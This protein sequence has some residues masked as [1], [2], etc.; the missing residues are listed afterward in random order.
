MVND[1]IGLDLS[2]RATGLA[3]SE[4]AYTYKPKTKAEKR[5]FD[6]LFYVNGKVSK[7][8]VVILE[9]YA[10]RALG[11]VFNIGELGGVIK[12]H[13]YT[14]GIPFAVIPPA[15]LKVYATGKGNASKKMMKQ[16]AYDAGGF[17][18]EDDNQCDA[19]W[20]RQM[21]QM[22]YAFETKTI[23]PRTDKQMTA[24]EKVEWPYA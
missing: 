20:L 7:G 15:N 23:F 16:A 1:I 13:F 6:I 2:L 3:D 4:G 10:M 12:Y 9:G 8:D 22:W 11:R 21:G 14:N 24:L 17:E 19:F 5:L 18:F